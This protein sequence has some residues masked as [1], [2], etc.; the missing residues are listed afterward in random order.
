MDYD[1]S[2][3]YSNEIEVEVNFTPTE[4]ALYQNYPNPFNPGTTIEFTVP[5]TENIIITI[6]DMIGREIR[7]L[8]SG[9]VQAGTYKVEWNG[10]NNAGVQVSSGSYLY[11]LTSGNFV[12]SKKLILLK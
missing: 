1:R 4:Y 9:K 12:Q 3:A 5:E 10:K 8:F 11:R 7:T 6:F 2:Y